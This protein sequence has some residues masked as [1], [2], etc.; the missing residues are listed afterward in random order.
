M[1][2]ASATKLPPERQLS[3][4]QRTFADLAPDIV[5]LVYSESQQNLDLAQARLWDIAKDAT[6]CAESV[7]R[8]AMRSHI[9]QFP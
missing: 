6:G 3:I 5:A 4:L 2:A 7:R 8:P 1:A 9:C